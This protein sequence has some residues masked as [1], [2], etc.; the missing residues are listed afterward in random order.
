M[1]DYF[2]RLLGL[3]ED[4]EFPQ[5]DPSS[6]HPVPHPRTDSTADDDLAWGEVVEEIGTEQQVKGPAAAAAAASLFTGAPS[7][8]A[9]SL[10]RPPVVVHP[11]PSAHMSSPD[12]TLATGTLQ[13]ISESGLVR[14]A[15]GAREFTESAPHESKSRTAPAPEGPAPAMP[16]PEAVIQQVLQWVAAAPSWPSITE[17]TTKPADAGVS[18][19]DPAATTPHTF[20]DLE[21]LPPAAVL[22]LPAVAWDPETAA[23]ANAPTPPRLA[24]HIGAVHVTVETPRSA[25]AINPPPAP[26]PPP[27]K[28]VLRSGS[29]LSRHYVSPSF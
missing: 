22:P 17:T 13:E 3:P 28:P 11:E 26:T 12:S 24:I 18:D 27:P 4:D 9:S 19:P 10:S 23:A 25:P 7:P 20:P 1:S 14:T 6:L 15:P 16:S 21:L 2:E 8:A 29:R 5:S